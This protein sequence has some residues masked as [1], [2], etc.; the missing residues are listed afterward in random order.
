MY[1]NLAPAVLAMS[2]GTYT[3][4]R[5]SGP[6]YSAGRRVAPTG[7]SITIVASVQPASGLVVRRLPEGKRNREAMSVFAQTELKSAQAAQ[8]PDLIAIDGGS[9]EVES[10]SR[11]NKLGNYYEAVVLRVDGT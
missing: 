7:S 9:F 10:V 11:W 4:T 8:E 3:V 6:S 2:S 1:F 5:R